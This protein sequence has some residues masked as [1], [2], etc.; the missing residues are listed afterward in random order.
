MTNKIINRIR[1][2]VDRR[3]KQFQKNSLSL[4]YLIYLSYK[5]DIDPFNLLNSFVRAEK[6]HTAKCGPLKIV[7]RTRGIDY[8]I[9]LVTRGAKLVA[10][11]KMNSELWEIPEKVN[12]LY[13]ELVDV[14]Q[15]FKKL[16][17]SPSSINDMQMGMKNVDLR[18]KVTGKSEVMYQYSRYDSNPLSLCIATITDLSGS[19]RLPLWNDQIDTLCVGDE[20]EITNASI[21]AFQGLLQI[22]PNR[23]TGKLVIVEH[24]KP[25][26]KEEMHTTHGN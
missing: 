4:E 10:Q 16:Y 1:K 20:I 18:A 12:R 3:G 9:F 24:T 25:A 7:V 21:K 22:V 13:S 5:H 6:I 14:A 8:A 23:N 17:E 15:P 26:K 19:I 2:S 11:M